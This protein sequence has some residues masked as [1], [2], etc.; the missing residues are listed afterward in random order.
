MRSHCWRSTTTAP[1]SCKTAYSPR[2][3]AGRGALPSVT[4]SEISQ[5]GLGTCEGSARTFRTVARRS[6]SAV[7]LIGKRCSTTVPLPPPSMSSPRAEPGVWL[8]TDPR[9]RTRLSCDGPIPHV[10]EDPVKAIRDSASAA[11]GLLPRPHRP[12]P[13]R[14][15]DSDPI[16]RQRGTEAIA[17]NPSCAPV[18]RVEV[19]DEGCYIG[20]L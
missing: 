2:A 13:A 15:I 10:N 20:L 1:Q 7:G 3:V 12:V 8:S 16:G 11:P 4:R 18:T 19:L 17:G 14:P 6:I 9:K 5:R